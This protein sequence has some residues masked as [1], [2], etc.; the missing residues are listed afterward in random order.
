[1]KSI[2]IIKLVFPDFEVI[3]YDNQNDLYEGFVFVSNSFKYR[4]RLAKK[5][6]KKEGYFV[7]FWE[8]IDGINHPYNKE[9]TCDYFIILVIDEE[10]KG[11]FKIPKKDLIEKGI[12][13]SET[14]KGKMGMRVYPS[15]NLGLLNKEAS[16]TQ[17]WQLEY[18]YNL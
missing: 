3:Q 2:N 10:N 9:D 17:K 18:F 8:K 7:T 6:P 16:K 12:V 13:K 1:M 4:S 11:Y 15:W 14:Q 5:T